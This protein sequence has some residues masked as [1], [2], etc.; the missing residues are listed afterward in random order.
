MVPP[1]HGRWQAVERRPEGFAA[2][3]PLGAGKGHRVA[4]LLEERLFPR[5]AVK[6]GHFVA[7]VF[8]A[9]GVAVVQ[10]AGQESLCACCGYFPTDAQGHGVERLL[11]RPLPS[12]DALDAPALRFRIGILH[13]PVALR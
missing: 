11:A 2:G 3:L 13:Q 6:N 9:G 10:D 12:A 4:V 1:G 5:L 7:A 8:F